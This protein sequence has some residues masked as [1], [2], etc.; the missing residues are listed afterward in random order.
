MENDKQVTPID[1]ARAT[2]FANGVYKVVFR[3]KDD[4]IR[5][6]VCTTDGKHVIVEAKQPTDNV[7][8]DGTPKV[9]KPRALN[10]NIKCVFDLEAK[11]WRSFRWDS[12]IS[13]E[14]IGV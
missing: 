8:E 4:T 3:K 5:E 2:D 12:V 9:S 6:M 1:S 11:G 7:N 14:K 10:S 13:V